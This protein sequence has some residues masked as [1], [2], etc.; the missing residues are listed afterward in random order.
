PLRNQRVV[1]FGAGVAG[2]GIAD[3]I[4]DAM[5]REGLSRQDA[6]ARIWCVDRAGLVREEMPGTQPD[7][8]Q[9]R[10]ARPKAEAHAW[11]RYGAGIG[12]AEVVHQVE[13]TMLI[14]ASACPGAFTKAIVQEIAAHAA[15]PIIF[16]VS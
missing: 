3:Q 13:P 2:I 5:V 10:Y 4:R 1:I 16:P 14:G 9:A 15:R 7:P 6:I 8:Y 12:L 11:L